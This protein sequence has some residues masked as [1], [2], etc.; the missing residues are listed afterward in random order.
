MCIVY[1][2]RLLL[3][4]GVN[5]NRATL[6][7]TCLHE[8]ALFGKTDVVKLLLDVSILLYQSF[9]ET[10]SC[11]T[12]FKGALHCV[13]ATK[14]QVHPLPVQIQCDLVRGTH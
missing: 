2:F 1:I 12:P 3:Q 11:E 7:G 5:I 6:Q 14:A 10:F 8:A 13:A 4:A 9:M